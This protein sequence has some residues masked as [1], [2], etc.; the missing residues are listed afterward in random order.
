MAHD[1]DGWCVAIDPAH[2]NCGIYGSRP[3]V[4]RRFVMDGPYCHAVRRDYADERARA[5]HLTLV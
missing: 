2:M 1:E 4:C 3:D 5:I